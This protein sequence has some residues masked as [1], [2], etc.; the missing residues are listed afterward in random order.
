MIS[1]LNPMLL[2]SVLCFHR[3]RLQPLVQ[4]PPPSP[5][6]LTNGYYLQLTEFSAPT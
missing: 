6:W 3:T 5:P 1:F 4:N 2:G